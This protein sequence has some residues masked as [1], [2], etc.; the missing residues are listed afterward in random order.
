MSL[1]FS[2][3]LCSAFLVEIVRAFEANHKGHYL[4][5]TAMQKLAYFSQSL[6]VPIPCSF[7]IYNFGPYSDT[8]TFNV[9]SMLADDILKD[10]SSN[11]KYSNYRL[12]SQYP[13]FEASI[14]ESVA[15]HRKTIER[16]V[17][18]L[19]KFD[20]GQLEVLATVHFIAKKIQSLGGQ[21]TKD[22]V[23]SQFFRIKG[24]KFPTKEVSS[25]YDALRVANLI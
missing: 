21:P 16:V 6:G 9:E 18:V 25:W 13:Q 1:L 8:V 15:P 5:R 11:Q 19:G 12:K 20:A 10:V 7:E 14:S 24:Q 23:L 22:A 4:G 3:D 17:N 2:N